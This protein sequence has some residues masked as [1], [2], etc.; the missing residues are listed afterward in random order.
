MQQAKGFAVSD[1]GR[2]I[3]IGDTPLDVDC[4]KA[5]GAKAIAVATGTFDRAALEASGADLVL[6]TLDEAARFGEW[7]AR[8]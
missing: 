1:P 6:D 7:L 2:V 8:H 5:H 3:V 4:A